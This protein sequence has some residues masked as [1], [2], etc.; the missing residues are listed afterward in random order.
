MATKRKHPKPIFTEPEPQVNITPVE[1]AQPSPTRPPAL[2]FKAKR[3]TWHTLPPRAVRCARRGDIPDNAPVVQARC[4][5]CNTPMWTRDARFEDICEQCEFKLIE[6][7]H[8]LLR[9]RERENAGRFINPWYQ[10]KNTPAPHFNPFRS[11]P[12]LLR[13]E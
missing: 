7:K 8:Q 6:E 1:A 2:N 4:T 11:K 13:Y 9:Q 12:G 5:H 10:E 3:Y